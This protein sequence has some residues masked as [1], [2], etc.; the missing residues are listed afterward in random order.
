MNNWKMI[1][2][3]IIQNIL[4]ERKALRKAV[5]TFI[6]SLIKFKNIIKEE[7]KLSYI[8]YFYGP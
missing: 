2:S 3:L 4:L 6:F 7:I 1:I 8:K 5:K